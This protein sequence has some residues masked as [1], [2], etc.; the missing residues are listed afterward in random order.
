MA[1][2]TTIAFTMYTHQISNLTL[3]A[4]YW[5]G[6]PRIGRSKD[7]LKT[8][9][10]FIPKNADGIFGKIGSVENYFTLIIYAGIAAHG[11]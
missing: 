4:K 1:D 11:I 6:L 9:T 7:E 5:C 2:S 10:Q 8:Y 3:P